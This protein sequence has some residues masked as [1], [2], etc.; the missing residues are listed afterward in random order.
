M[1]T[2]WWSGN[3][4]LFQPAIVCHF[5]IQLLQQEG[6]CFTFFHSLFS[7]FVDFIESVVQKCLVHLNQ[8][9]HVFWLI[10]IKTNLIFFHV[11]ISS[12]VICWRPQIWDNPSSL[13]PLFVVF[14]NK[15][16]KQG[17]FF[18]IRHSHLARENRHWRVMS[19]IPIARLAIDYDFMKSQHVLISVKLGIMS[20]SMPELK[21]LYLCQK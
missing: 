4:K 14:F 2:P 6:K 10:K 17:C 5:C 18:S 11:F 15:N 19:S 16:Q 9:R 20:V 12:I 13:T 21:L 8:L 7:I 1:I 3:F